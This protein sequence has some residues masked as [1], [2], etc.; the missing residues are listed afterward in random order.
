MKIVDVLIERKI[1]SLNRPFS[2][3]AKDDALIE[4]G[5]RV[6]VP[7]NNKNIVGYVINVTKSDKSIAE[8]E[9]EFGYKLFE[10][11][12]II[13]EKPLL[14]PE[15]ILLANEIKNYYNEPAIYKTYNPKKDFTWIDISRN[16]THTQLKQEDI[17][18]YILENE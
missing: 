5:E 13:D 4:V 1:Q 10:V 6:L 16:A 14:T 7:F 18:K 8:L 15:L 9:K 17:I 2:Y 3:V 11:R 12:K